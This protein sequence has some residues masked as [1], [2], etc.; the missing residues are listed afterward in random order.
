MNYRR[1]LDR[2][3]VEEKL[4]TTRSQAESYIR[5]GA[6][7]VDGQVVTKPGVQVMPSNKVQ[8]IVEEQYVSRAGLKLSSI[9]QALEL[10]FKNK[11]VLDVGSSTGGFTDFALKN[12]AAKVIAVDVG[13]GQMHPLLRNDPRIE[14]HEQTDLRHMR[15]LTETVDC[16]LIDVSFISI[17]EILDHLPNLIGLKTEIVAMVKPQ[18]EAGSGFKHKG[19]IKN[20]A[21][22]REILKEFEDWVK[23][24]YKVINKA[25]SH[26]KGEKGNTERF[27]LLKLLG[28]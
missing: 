11:I 28:S 2:A 25:D 12:G 22:R 10:K 20:E 18:F 1:R 3:L 5:M 16:V 24:K 19:V 23:R 26:I 4:V 7:R 17:R 8:L 14:L 15:K 27:Y 9:T 6:V 21:M 13:S